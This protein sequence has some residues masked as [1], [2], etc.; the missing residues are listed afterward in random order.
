MINC[1]TNFEPVPNRHPI[2][3]WL[4]SKFHPKPEETILKDR[5]R[6]DHMFMFV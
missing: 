5:I 4:R 6:A 2:L 1:I 3:T